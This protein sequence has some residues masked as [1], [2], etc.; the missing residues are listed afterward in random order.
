M[1]LPNK[2]DLFGNVNY[3]V[4]IAKII[5]FSDVM[6]LMKWSFANDKVEVYENY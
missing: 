2:Y 5:Q 4:Q 6:D 3:M 1:K